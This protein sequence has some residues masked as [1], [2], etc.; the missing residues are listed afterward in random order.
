M[1]EGVNS[2]D[3]IYSLDSLIKESKQYEEYDEPEWGFQRRKINMKTIMNAQYAI[4]EETDFIK[5]VCIIFKI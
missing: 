5:R 4:C 2:N 1:K 3:G